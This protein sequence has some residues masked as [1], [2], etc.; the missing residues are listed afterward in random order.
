MTSVF[1][2]HTK[3]DAH[4]AQ[5]LKYLLEDLNIPE[6]R[7]FVSSDNDSITAGSS[8]FASL[9][10]ALQ[11]CKVCVSILTANSMYKPWIAFETGVVYFRS[12]ISNNSE[13]KA[14]PCSAGIDLGKLISPYSQLQARNLSE[15]KGVELLLNDILQSVTELSEKQISSNIK[16]I[17]EKIKN[18]NQLILS[19][20]KLSVNNSPSY[21][22]E[23]KKNDQELFEKINKIFPYSA[24]M[25]YIETQDFGG[26]IMRES[27]NVL[28]DVE[29]IDNDPNYKFISPEIEETKVKVFNAMLGFLRT[30]AKLTVPDDRTPEYCRIPKALCHQ[31]PVEH[32]KR[33]D[34]ITASANELVECYG[35]F[36]DTKK[37]LLS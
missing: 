28:Y 22:T 11:G 21:T 29:T 24:F 19:L 34:E 23:H 32:K 20:P 27:Y 13:I 37:R 17:S 35:K 33:V 18:F 30:V 6:S 5:K 1:I 26:I 8:W 16:N 10:I 14:I 4:I 36:I 31:D 15:T 3:D 2:S 25:P 9:M 7:I 12:T